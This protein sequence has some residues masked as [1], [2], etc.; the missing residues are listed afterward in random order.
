MT[1]VCALHHKKAACERRV[2]GA[3]GRRHAGA[4]KR[5]PARLAALDETEEVRR[6]AVQLADLRGGRPSI[7]T[8]RPPAGRA[9]FGESRMIR[10]R[11]SSP[12]SE[13]SGYGRLYLLW[14]LTAVGTM[15]E[16]ESGRCYPAQEED[17]R[18]A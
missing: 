11:T 14:N 3:A 13:R 17:A 1:Y 10:R 8:T 12:S 6:D 7:S 4:L 5:R 18:A 2:S 9:R 15:I 16:R